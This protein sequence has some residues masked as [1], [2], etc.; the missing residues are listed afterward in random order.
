[1]RDEFITKYL[2][3]LLKKIESDTIIE[4]VIQMDITNN[5]T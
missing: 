3:L 4:C 5:Y 1:M 2:L